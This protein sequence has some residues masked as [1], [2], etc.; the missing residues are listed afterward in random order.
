MLERSHYA[1]QT[2]P[3]VIWYCCSQVEVWSHKSLAI[4]VR[5]TVTVPSPAILLQ[6]EKLRTAPPQASKASGAGSGMGKLMS[7]PHVAV[8]PS[9][10]GQ[11]EMLGS[12]LSV[13]VRIWLAEVEAS[14]IPSK[15]H[16]AVHPPVQP[17][18]SVV[19]LMLGP[20]KVASHAC[21][22][23]G[24][25]KQ[26]AVA[27][28]LLRHASVQTFSDGASGSIESDISGWT[29]TKS[30]HLCSVPPPEAGFSP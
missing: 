21:V 20:L 17:H 29:V 19:S 6:H 22:Y 13:I 4:Q 24:A 8:P 9:S 28:P 5:L 16:V 12:P 2:P 10:L 1:S 15:V 11:F 25:T 26:Y 3:L 18:E 23:P 7:S 14:H 30:E 27:T